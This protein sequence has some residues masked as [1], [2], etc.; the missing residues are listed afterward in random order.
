MTIASD[1]FRCIPGGAPL[2]VSVPHDGRAIPE[3]LRA[4]MTADG[5]DMPDTDWHV[6]R[7]Y[8]FVVDMDATL[9]VANYSRYVIDL[10][11]PAGDTALYPGQV[12]TGLCPAQTFAGDDIYADGGGVRDEEKRR[13]IGRYWQ[14]YHDKLASLL[15]TTRAEHGYALLWDA[16]S[17]PS[18][19]PRLFD[20]QLPVF[21]IGTYDGNSCAPPLAAAVHRVATDSDYSTVVNGRFK[22]GFITR[23]Y[24][25]PKTGIHA[26]QLELAQRAYMDEESRE[27]DEARAG[28]LRD[29]LAGM[30]KSYLQAGAGLKA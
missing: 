23:H 6:A 4:R 5:R 19:V 29:T 28:S 30:L 24:G 27:F 7:L 2:I 21:N 26:L 9:L 13:R 8:E 17:I 18:R 11:R 22:G 10:N 14:P 15:E 3:N 20:G 25:H 12:T 16:H 1:V